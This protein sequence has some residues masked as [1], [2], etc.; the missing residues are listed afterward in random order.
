[1]TKVELRV[2]LINFCIFGTLR[3]FFSLFFSLDFL[4]SLL[5]SEPF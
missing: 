4:G 3:A 5:H 1:M 2:I